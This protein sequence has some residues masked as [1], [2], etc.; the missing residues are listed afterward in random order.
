M[1][2]RRQNHRTR[3]F[4]FWMQCQWI[5]ET[6]KKIVYKIA[7]NNFTKKWNVQLST[8]FVQYRKNDVIRNNSHLRTCNIGREILI[9]STIVDVHLPFSDRQRQFS[10]NGANKK[11]AWTVLL[12][13]KCTPVIDTFWRTIYTRARQ[14]WHASAGSQDFS[15]TTRF[16]ARGADKL[17][18]SQRRARRASA[19]G[20][21]ARAPRKKQMLT[22]VWRKCLFFYFNH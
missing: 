3:Y 14:I 10:E 16:P 18:N 4:N 21:S 15:P 6:N 2:S 13:N 8:A 19:M 12:W 11:R 20:A 1:S 5:L 17:P 22:F 9:L 7:Y